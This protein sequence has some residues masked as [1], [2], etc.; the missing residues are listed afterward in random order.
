MY[1]RCALGGRGGGIE[2]GVSGRERR[3]ETETMTER[4]RVGRLDTQ[5]N[6]CLMKVG[7]GVWERIH[8]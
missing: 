8:K 1:S 6:T 5:E 3:G 2:R 7:G 4:E